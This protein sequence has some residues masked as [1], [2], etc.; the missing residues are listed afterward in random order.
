MFRAA[1]CKRGQGTKLLQ[2]S[3]ARFQ[4][5]KNIS[6]T[7]IYSLWRSGHPGGAA[8]RT[9]ATTTPSATA[10]GSTATAMR[11][12]IAAACAHRAPSHVIAASIIVIEKGAATWRRHRYA[13]CTRAVTTAAAR[14]AVTDTTCALVSRQQ[15]RQ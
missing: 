15:Q 2:G 4:L 13:V 14:E 12:S 1:S 9:H 11:A 6:Y 5:T 3:I 10:E 7:L 8:A